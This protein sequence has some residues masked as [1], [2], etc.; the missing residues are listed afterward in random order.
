MQAP[1]EQCVDLVFA[2]CTTLSELAKHPDDDLTAAIEQVFDGYD[3]AKLFKY[4]TGLVQEL[5]MERV[6]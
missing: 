6:R 3:T 1:T 5:E 2:L 4:L